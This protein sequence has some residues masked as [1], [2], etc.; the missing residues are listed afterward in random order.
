[1]H[2]AFGPDHIKKDILTTLVIKAKYT[3]ID[4]SAVPILC[5]DEINCKDFVQNIFLFSFHNS[6]DSEYGLRFYRRHRRTETSNCK[7]P[8]LV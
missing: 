5:L 4:P 7:L 1:M 8:R 2:V 6:I 3:D